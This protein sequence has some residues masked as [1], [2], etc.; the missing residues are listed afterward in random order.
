[1]IKFSYHFKQLSVSFE[2]YA[3]L[4]SVSGRF[5]MAEK[6]SNTSYTEKYH[7]HIS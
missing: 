3:D 1:M 4:E 7:E 2:I 6:D 5:N